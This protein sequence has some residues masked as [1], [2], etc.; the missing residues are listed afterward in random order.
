MFRYIRQLWQSPDL[1]RQILITLWLLLMYRVVA[2]ITVPGTDPFALQQFLDSRSGVGAVGVFAALTGGAIDNFSVVM[3]GLSPY[4]NASIIVQLCTVIFPKLEA[5]SKE[6][7]QGQQQLNRYTRYLAVPLAIV[8]SYG[9]LILLGQGG[10]QLVDLSFPGVLAPMLFVA[11]G[12]IFLMWLGELITEKG[13]GNGISLIIFTGIVSGIPSIVSSMFIA[14]EG[15]IAAFYLFGIVSLAM[16]VAVV[17]FTDAHRLIPI[18]Y[19]SQG[20]GRGVQGSIPIRLNQ[21]GMIPIIFAISLITMPAIVAQFL[22]TAERFRPVVGFINEY[23]N[24]QNPSILYMLIYFLLVVGFTYFY[25]SVTFKPDDIADTIQKRG[26]FIPGV[27]P[28]KATA[29]LLAKVSSRMNL[30]G[31]SFLGIVAIVPLVF[32]RYSALSSQ[33]L[34]ISGSGLIIVVGVVMELI[35]QIN[36]Q[37]LAHDYEKLV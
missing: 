16:L 15:K 19:A 10:V 22:S 4:I 29:A 37:L 21:A 1:R 5:I 31:G 30:W 26:G 34:I 6:G 17:L 13:I 20:A 32:T 12:S 3:L 25:V 18:T 35:R 11:T 27:R 7:A 14:G 8:Q 24:P 33:D 2:H 9:F 23:I 36:A 28:G